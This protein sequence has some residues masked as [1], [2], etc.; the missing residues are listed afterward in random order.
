MKTSPWIHTRQL[1]AWRPQT[2]KISAMLFLVAMLFMQ[3][4]DNAPWWSAQPSVSDANLRGVSVVLATG[5]NDRLQYII[6]ASGS[7][8]VILRSIDEGSS[9]KQI[10]V[11]NADGLDFR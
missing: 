4:K 6:W 5:K 3:L 9:W 1:R 11:P 10:S 2:G 7:D 8:G